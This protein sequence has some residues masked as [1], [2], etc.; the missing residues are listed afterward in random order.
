MRTTRWG[1][2]I[3]LCCLL[4]LILMSVGP[5]AAHGYLVRA[6]PAD[7]SVL[8]RAPTRLQYWFSESLEPRFSKINVRD[9]KG[10]IVATGGVDPNN[11]TA[12]V[13]QIPPGMLPDGA[14]VVELGTAFASD[15]HS[16]V[17]SRV[18]FVGDVVNDVQGIAANPYAQP[19]EIV[20]KTLL[21][22]ST[23]LLFGIYATYVLVLV[24]VWGSA[25]HPLGLLPPRLIQRLHVLVVIGI[26]LAFVANILA[27][28]QQTM[29]FFNVDFMTAVSTDMWGIVRTSS[30]AGDVWTLRMILLIMLAVL[31]GSV[32]YSR[33][34]WPHLLYPTWLGNVWLVALIIGLQAVTSHAAGALT[35]PWIAIAMHWTHALSAAFWVG[36]IA[37]FVLILPTA[38]QPYD[39]DERQQALVVLMRAFSWLI[40]G[41]VAL[42][43]ASGIYNALNWFYGP[44]DVATTYGVTLLLKVLMVVLLLAFGAMHYLALN[45]DR[46][47]KISSW[48]QRLAPR[49]SL[50]LF[51][52][53]WESLVG[54]VVLTTAAVLSAT[55]IPQPLLVQDESPALTGTQIVNDVSVSLSVAPGVP[56]INTFDIVVER[57]GQPVTDAVVE[58]QLVLPER[59]ERTRWT[60]AEQVEQGLYVW[61]SD[62]IERVGQWSFLVDVTEA[63]GTRTRAAFQWPIAAD[64]TLIRPLSPLQIIALVLVV[65]A[66]GWV[67]WPSAKATAARLDWN[68]KVVFV[69]ASAI[70]LSGLVLGIAGQFLADQQS[71]TEEMLNPL[72]Q[73]I[74]PTLPDAA[75]LQRGEA[76]YKASCNLWETST[77]FTGLLRQLDFLRDDALYR[78]PV[79]GW[80]TIPACTAPLDEM[81]TWDVVNY[82]RSLQTTED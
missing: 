78:I 39:G 14:Y 24:P 27:L 21:I 2:P 63:S 30:R 28:I 57:D 13:V 34:E 73:I 44:Q 82:L 32:W 40:V 71:R 76:L 72:P 54:A 8:E 65:A 18:F 46:R 33:K 19:F 67:L 53:R 16:V 47:A 45:P 59:D 11:L 10:N 23:F 70:V 79:Q 25:Q 36:G 4:L 64:P 38:L 62:A 56:G 77:D 9:V 69:A 3:T 49:R 80:R 48:V 43:I 42:V 81:Q 29:A 26:A 7:R 35:Q 52:L 50:S 51:S 12:L 22:L 58:I 20:W 66:A 31:H 5:V 37:V 15:S 17:E 1:S 75:S 61:A 60:A 6:I 74:N 41:V 55:P 68:P